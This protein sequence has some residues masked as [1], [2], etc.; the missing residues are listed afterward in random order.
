VTRAA[1]VLGTSAGYTGLAFASRGRRE[2]NV[3]IALAS[4]VRDLTIP[5]DRLNPWLVGLYTLAGLGAIALSGSAIFSWRVGV[6]NSWMPKAQGLLVVF[7]DVPPRG[8][9]WE[10]L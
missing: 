6:S 2:G 7:R 10:L 8:N 3:G 9:E 1:S 5:S 4:T